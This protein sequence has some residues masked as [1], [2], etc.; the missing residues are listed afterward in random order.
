LIA[1]LSAKHYEYNVPRGPKGEKRPAYVI[2]K[3]V[4]GVFGG[5]VD[6]A[7]LVKL[8]GPPPEKRQG[9]V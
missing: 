1:H 5:D 9:S 7:Q 2:G 6:Y 8:L 3:A 4:E